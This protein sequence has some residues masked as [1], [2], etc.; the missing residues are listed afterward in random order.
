MQLAFGLGALAFEFSLRYLV[1]LYI[2]PLTLLIMAT[3]SAATGTCLLFRRQLSFA[4][5]D[6]KRRVVLQQFRKSVILGILAVAGF[7]AIFYRKELFLCI[8][9]LL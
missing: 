9:R 8:A 5:T 2:L 6:D 4:S 1:L 7:L 3:R